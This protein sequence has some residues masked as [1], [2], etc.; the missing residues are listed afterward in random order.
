MSVCR[1]SP[2]GGLVY[3]KLKHDTR[4]L[5]CS[6]LGLNEG[7]R[8]IS[9]STIL[10]L[11]K[12]TLAR[13]VR[14]LGGVEGGPQIQLRLAYFKLWVLLDRLDLELAADLVYARLGIDPCRDLLSLR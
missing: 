14:F 7:S 5:V 10:C 4:V 6:Y 3:L 13:V 11:Q 8:L 1:L 9:P 12:R 2:L